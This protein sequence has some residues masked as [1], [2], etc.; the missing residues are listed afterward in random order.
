MP[1]HSPAPTSSKFL[2]LPQT[3]WVRSR[4]GSHSSSAP[5]MEP[6]ISRQ[7]NGL[8]SWPSAPLTCCLPAQGTTVGA[9][10]S[11]IR[12]LPATRAAARDHLLLLLCDRASS[13][14]SAVEV[15]V[16]SVCLDPVSLSSTL[17][18]CDSLVSCETVADLRMGGIYVA[19]WK[20]GA[21]GIEIGARFG[22]PLGTSTAEWG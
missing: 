11:G 3:V 1:V 16:V 18:G 22:I 4:V 10:C 17:S 7:M 19:E 6:P 14:A 15:A 9:I 2:P 12:A 21:V 20:P 8:R 13:G 5:R